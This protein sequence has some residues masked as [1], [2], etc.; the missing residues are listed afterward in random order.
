MNCAFGAETFA[1]DTHVFRVGNRT[2]LARGKTPEQ[3]EAQ[4]REA[5]AAA[6]PPR[7]A[8]LADPARPLHLQGADAR[9]LALPGGGLVRATGR[10]C[11]NARKADR[12]SGAG[13]SARRRSV[14]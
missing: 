5:R 9:M 1:V 4:A 2:G 11:W 8:S 13:A 12:R 7:R 10:R 6:L 14:R 3:V